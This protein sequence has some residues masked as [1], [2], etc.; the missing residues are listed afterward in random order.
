MMGNASMVS[1]EQEAP[2]CIWPRTPTARILLTM[3]V[4][5]AMVCLMDVDRYP[6]LFRLGLG[7]LQRG[8]L[9]LIGSRSGLRKFFYFTMVI[10]ACEGV[11]A[12]VLIRRALRGRLGGLNALLWAL[13]TSFLGFPSLLLL[14][15]MLRDLRTHNSDAAAQKAQ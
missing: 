7:P 11:Y 12:L 5:Q 8:L 2:P 10:H 14:S 4:V 1:T 3:L 15:H 13:Q 9:T 6:H